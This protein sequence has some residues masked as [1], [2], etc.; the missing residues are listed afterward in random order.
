MMSK[1]ANAA[2]KT[3]P[4]GCLIAINAAIK[5]VLSPNSEIII[6]ANEKKNA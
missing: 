1:E 3:T 4:L 2:V 6:I 5:N